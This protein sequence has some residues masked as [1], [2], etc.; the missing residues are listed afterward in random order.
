M[1]FRELSGM[2]RAKHPRGKEEFHRAHFCPTVRWGYPSCATISSSTRSC[3]LVYPLLSEIWY[4][5]T[6]DHAPTLERQPP[7]HRTEKYPP[8]LSTTPVV[9]PHIHRLFLRHRQYFLHTN[10]NPFGVSNMYLTAQQPEGPAIPKTSL[11]S[12][13][14][15]D[16]CFS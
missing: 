3:P 10:R 15:G 14:R 16:F 8:P 2:F 1:D 5:T 7:C 13:R 9:L 6:F 12:P 4:I 11:F